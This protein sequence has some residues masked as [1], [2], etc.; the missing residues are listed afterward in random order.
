MA[1]QFWSSRLGLVFAAAGSAVGLGNF[2]RFP[3]QAYTNGGGSFL[4]PYI[5]CF[6]LIAIPLCWVEWSLG[7]MG[8][9]KGKHSCA[10]ILSL[11]TQSKFLQSF[12][13]SLAVLIPGGVYL[14]YAVI[15]SW[16]LAYFLVFLGIIDFGPMS[17]ADQT[18]VVFESIS[19]SSGNGFELSN[20]FW[21]LILTMLLNSLVIVS[22]FLNSIERFCL[23]AIPVMALCAFFVLIRVLTLGT[24]DP[25]FPERNVW[26]ALGFMWN[27][28]GVD[29]PNWLNNLLNPQIWLSA[30]GQVF[31]SLSVG[32]GILMHYASYVRKNQ[33]IALSSF[34]ASSTN[35]FFEVCVGGLITIPVI[36]LFLG[37]NFNPDSSFSLGFIS[38]PLVFQKMT[39]GNL[40]GALWFLMLFLAAITSAISMISPV[41][42]FIREYFDLGEKKARVVGTLIL[43]GGN[44]LL[45][46]F[47]KNLT[48]L[49]TLDFWIGT[50]AVF[51]F[52][53]SFLLIAL[54]EIGLEKILECIKENALINVPNFTK[55][56]LRW[57]APFLFVVIFVSWLILNCKSLVSS[58]NSL[59]A[60]IA[61]GIIILSYLFLSSVIIVRGGKQ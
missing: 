21:C 24:P 27:P 6:F 49:S 59:E 10:G 36:F 60:F 40:F 41:V 30:F 46:Y 22:G 52:C 55:Y 56:L 11:F 18:K 33:D 14:Y 53:A 47:S 50:V 43:S 13:G 61:V 19:K 38:M 32:L 58:I 31:F 51:L 42:A 20:A 5:V 26:N 16:C 37:E 54:R 34:S 45:Y 48:L 3:G 25:E 12:S 23:I 17:N 4:V 57:I 35:G 15:Q 2:L 44:L 28:R 39:W 8:G 29:D 9:Q 7:K 1:S